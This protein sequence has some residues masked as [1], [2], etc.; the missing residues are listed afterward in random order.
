M[1]KK[2]STSVVS[3]RDCGEQWANTYNKKESVVVFQ[4]IA[5]VSEQLHDVCGNSTS[6]PDCSAVSTSA[7]GM[8]LTARIEELQ[9][10]L[11]FTAES[12]Y[13]AAFTLPQEGLIGV[14]A[15]PPGSVT[16]VPPESTEIARAPGPSS[17]SEEGSFCTRVI[18]N[19]SNGTIVNGTCQQVSVDTNG[20]LL[21][22]EMHASSVK[23]S[24]RRI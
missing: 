10:Q 17:E 18:G 4:N 8:D 15:P 20:G 1:E 9:K 2:A 16:A 6:R 22:R 5:I 12:P 23:D 7:E 19:I 3:S 24:C 14:P 11:P 21:D 13:S